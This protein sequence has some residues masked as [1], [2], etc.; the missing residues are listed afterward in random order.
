MGQM[1]QPCCEGDPTDPKNI[2]Y[3]EKTNMNTPQRGLRRNT[4][5]SS[6]SQSPKYR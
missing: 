6:Q 1:Q 4:R 3:N 2:Y 5:H